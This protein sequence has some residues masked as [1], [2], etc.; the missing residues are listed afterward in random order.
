MAKRAR[1]HPLRFCAVMAAVLMPALAGAAPAVDTKELRAKLRLVNERA[2]LTGMDVPELL[3]EL[4]LRARPIQSGQ[5]AQSFNNAGGLF[6]QQKVQEVT[7]QAVSP[8][9]AHAV[10]V[11]TTNFRLML[12]TLSQ[13]YTGQNNLSVITAQGARG[14]QAVSVRGGQVSLADLQSLSAAQGM[15]PRLDG[16]LTAPVVLWED[17][18]L[19]LRPGERLALARDT[20]AF[21]MSMGHIEAKGAVIESAGPEN[22]HEKGFAPFVTVLGTGSITVENSTLRGLGFG[23][24]A[25]FGGLTVAGNPLMRSGG[26]VILR[27]SLFDGMRMVTV[28]GVPD[29]VITGN[30]FQDAKGAA[31]SI[32]SAQGAVVRENLFRGKAPTNAI[33]VE[34]GSSMIDISQNVFLAGDRV[35][36]LV[37]GG[38]YGVVV[39]DNIVWK[40]NGAGLKFLNTRCSRAEGNILIDNMQK[41]IEVRKSNGTVVQGNLLAGNHSSGVWV[42]AQ[43]DGARTLVQNNIFDGNGSGLSAA[44][45]AEIWVVHNNFR[46]QLPKLLDG[47]ISLLTG[48]LVR[49][50]GG[51][52]PLRFARGQTRTLDTGETLCGSDT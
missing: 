26:Q 32:Q 50:L 41:G 25:K 27:D 24:T 13:T 52:V 19:V 46:G 10:G 2:A 33:R 8:L 4:G 14:A 15:P 37:D 23:R 40:R 42:S 1:L 28:A 16:T 38:S 9:G 45:G 11:S 5:S 6:S 49:D 47:D 21:L 18:T 44:T 22:P 17:A 3:A 43:R 39:R 51:A 48:A 12:A 35:A 30:T 29:A 31:L 34:L 7:P 20:G 36:M